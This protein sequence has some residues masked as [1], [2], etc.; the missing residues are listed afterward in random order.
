MRQL[1]ITYELLSCLLGTRTPFLVYP[2]HQH[3]WERWDCIFDVYAERRNRNLSSLL[4][5]QPE[6]MSSLASWVIVLGKNGP[7]T[8]FSIKATEH[9][10]SRSSDPH[11]WWLPLPQ[12]ASTEKRQKIKAW[13]PPF[14]VY[15]ICKMTEEWQMQTKEGLLYKRITATVEY[16]FFPLYILEDSESPIKK[17]K[18]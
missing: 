7:H 13:P 14:L 3:G 5:N 2:A 8:H 17:K 12:L 18:K 15:N 10:N 16:S 11:F 4:T 6:R 9:K 1:N